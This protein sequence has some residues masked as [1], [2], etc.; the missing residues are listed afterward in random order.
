[1]GQPLADFFSDNEKTAFANRNIELGTVV[2]IYDRI[3]N[4][5]KW[6][7][8]VGVSNDEIMM[9]SVRINSE[10]NLNCIPE[11]FRRYHYFITK[12]DNAFLEH[13]SY[14][15]CS[16]LIIRKKKDFVNC[17]AKNSMA[18]K[19]KMEENKLN[20]IR[21]TIADCRVI[22]PKFKKQFCLQ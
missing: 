22:E 11:A 17:V 12:K 14:V 2:K 15:D 5:E 8:I 7:L 18:L 20:H 10:L 9:A 4:K 21:A 6:H 19:G 1:M 16:K 3:A 13:D